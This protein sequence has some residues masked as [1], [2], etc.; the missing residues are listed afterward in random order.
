MTLYKV[1]TGSSGYC[2]RLIVRKSLVA[3]NVGNTVLTE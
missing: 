2:G 3:V 1:A